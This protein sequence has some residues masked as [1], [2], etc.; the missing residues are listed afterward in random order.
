MPVPP[1]P[2]SEDNPDLYIPDIVKQFITH[3]YNQVIEK[4]SVSMFVNGYCLHNSYSITQVDILV[5]ASLCIIVINLSFTAEHGRNLEALREWVR[6]VFLP[7]MWLIC[8]LICVYSFRRLSERWFTEFPWPEAERIAQFVN[9]GMSWI[10]T[11]YLSCVVS[12]TRWILLD[13][14]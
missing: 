1:P 14:L 9:N 10:L 6:I 4:V 7:V 12:L 5:T 13:T 2:P 3:F 11:T 8:L